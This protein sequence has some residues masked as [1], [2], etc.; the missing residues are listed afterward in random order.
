MKAKYVDNDITYYGKITSLQGINDAKA[1]NTLELLGVICAPH[2][3]IRAVDYE[4][5]FCCIGMTFSQKFMQAL[6]M[7]NTAI[8]NQILYCEKVRQLKAS[9]RN[10]E[11]YKLYYSILGKKLDG[12]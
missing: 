7:G 12:L 10:L 1:H 3:Q 6:P 8:W 2:E 9:E 5:D 11:I 4:D